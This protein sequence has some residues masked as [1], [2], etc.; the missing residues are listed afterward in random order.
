[1]SALSRRVLWMFAGVMALIVAELSW[2]ITF[3][4]R[5]SHEQARERLLFYEIQEKLAADMIIMSTHGHAD[6]AIAK[7]I[8]TQHFPELEWRRGEFSNPQLGVLYPHMGP[9]VREDVIA[10][11]ENR[12]A[13]HVR[14]F[15]SEGGFFMAMLLVGGALVLRT[16][17]HDVRLMRQQANFLAAV[18]H[19]LKSPLASIRLYTE[20]MQLRDPPQATRTR[21][22]SAIHADVERLEG[23]VAN[24]LA[25]ARLEAG[26]FVMYPEALDLVRETATIVKA[27]EKELIDRFVPVSMHLPRESL[28]VHFDALALQTVMRNLLDN[29][30][31]Y[32]GGANKPVEV[33]VFAEGGKAVVEVK[34]QG[35]G[36][37]ASEIG[38]IFRKFYRVGDEMVRQTEGS[39]LGL[40]L[41]EQLVTQ[42]GGTVIAQSPGTG[43][44][45]VMRVS[46]P[47]IKSEQET[48]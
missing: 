26:K 22:L 37:A 14:M 48:A 24:L 8:L 21:Y 15:I 2:W 20:T 32:S 38:K 40:Y 1:M 33:R 17:R 31:K 13:A 11:L 6:E 27:V 29:A 39:G 42:S 25:V 28:M 5:T 3:H 36:I 9:Y 45:T 44:G 41:V 35:I 18:T 23:L 7:T 46:L 10:T 34:D 4:V 43:F 16:M 19:E 47:L 30:A 12:D